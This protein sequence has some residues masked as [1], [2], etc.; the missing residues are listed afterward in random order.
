MKKLSLS[1]LELKAID[2]LQREELKTVFGGYYGN[3][4]CSVTVEC[5]INGTTTTIT[6]TSDEFDCYR[7]FDF[8]MCDKVQYKCYE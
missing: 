3:D 1:N 8:V 2:L 4:F 7:G 6:C 5:N